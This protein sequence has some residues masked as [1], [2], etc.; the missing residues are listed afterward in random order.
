MSYNDMVTEGKVYTKFLSIVPRDG[1]YL[2]YNLTP[3]NLS[4]LK[5]DGVNFTPDIQI[6]ITDLNSGKKRFLN[7]TGV[8]DKFKINVIIHKNETV[9][10][11]RVVQEEMK[12]GQG[13]Y[14]LYGWYGGGK[15]ILNQSWNLIEILDS[16]IRN[17][18]IFTVTTRA[19][20]IPNGAYII[21]GNSNRKQTYDD[22]TVWELEFT[23]YVGNVVTAVTWNNTYAQKAVST[24]N[25]N[26]EKAAAKTKEIA[27]IKANFKKC[28]YK[29]M[30]YTKKAKA[31]T[32]NKYL[33]QLL[34]K[35]GFANT[36]ISGWY[37]PK[38]KEGVSKFQKKYKSKYNL[39]VT[40]NMD[41]K[42][43]NAML[44]V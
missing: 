14:G 37:G 20:D 11:E 32:C 18:T 3:I 22:Y 12:Y 40:G 36:Q 1:S 9:K 43:F 4:V 42:T 5:G 8:G 16:W 21:T 41:K 7:H 13:P 29:K 19:V 10:G 31:V 26:K 44:K 25:K 38:T 24:Y 30:V 15:R 17:M 23:R 28:D 27:A 33:Q 39:S 6:K 34:K 2:D 35:W